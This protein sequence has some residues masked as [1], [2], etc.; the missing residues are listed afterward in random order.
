IHVVR[1]STIVTPFSM[2]SSLIRSRSTEAADASSARVFTPSVSR[3]SGAM[4]AATFPP[5]A[6]MISIASVRYS[7]PCT[8][9]GWIC[10]SA[11]HNAGAERPLLHGDLHVRAR[12][13]LARRRR[14]DDDER[15]G[16]C[17]APR[18]HDP[19]DHA[20]AEDRMEVL[21]HRGLHPRAEAAGHQD[22]C[23]G[24]L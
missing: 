15:A 3:E 19:V 4:C 20:T 17:L 10:S 14:C 24:R 23:E 21:R 12:E 1:G 8:L 5:P 22:C 11:G 9:C 6:T 7:S 18:L 13:L 16:A 2:C